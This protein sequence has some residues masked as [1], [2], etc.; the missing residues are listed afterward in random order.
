VNVAPP[1]ARPAGRAPRP[2]APPPGT[3]P[4]EAW[5]TLFGWC[6]RAGLAQGALLAD[7]G[8]SLREAFGELPAAD[9]SALAR[10]LA[11]ALGEARRTPGPGIAAVALDVDGQWV[12]G[13]AVAVPGKEEA[14]VGLAG[15][16][17]VRSE[18]RAA[19]AGWIQDALAR[20]D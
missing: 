8:G 18:M 3:A 20:Q 10:S 1:A 9:P 19:L 13:F 14:V 5:A 16:A 17:P 4:A 7:P 15:R 12:T 2:P 11:A 6:A